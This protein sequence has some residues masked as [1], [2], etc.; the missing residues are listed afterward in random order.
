MPNSTFSLESMIGAKEGIS[1]KAM[2]YFITTTY[3]QV[4]NCKRKNT[5]WYSVK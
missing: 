5:G 2:S 1:R 4:T 3:V